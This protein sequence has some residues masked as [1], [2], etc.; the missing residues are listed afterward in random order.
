MPTSLQGIAKKA[1]QEKSYRFRNLFGMLT[2]VYVLSGWPLLN[3]RAATGVDRI[4]ARAYGNRLHDHV[5]SLVERVKTQCYR[6]K[7]VRRHY[8]PK[9]NGALRPL[10]IPATEDKLLQMA[11]A[12]ILDAI[13]EPDFL[14]S[15]YGYRKKIGARDAVRDLTRQLQFGPYNYVVEADIKGFFDHI[16]HERLLEML[17]LRIEDRPFLRLIK[18]WLKAGVLDTDGQ[19]LHPVTGLPQGGIVSPILANIYLHHVLDVWF[20][21]VVQAYCKGQALLCRY[22]DDFVCA[23]Q[24][25]R[26]AE[27]FYGVLGQ[28]L[29]KYGL[30]LSPEKTR[31]LGFSRHPKDAKSRFDFLGFTFLWGKDRKGQDRLQ[32]QTS[33]SRLKKALSNFTAWIKQARNQHV[34]DLIKELNSKLRGYYNY[35]GVRGNFSSL[36][37]FFYHVERLL[38]KWLNRRSQKHSYTWQGFKDLLKQFAIARPRITEP[39]RSRPVTT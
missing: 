1:A 6:A 22:A 21:E 28:R 19:V 2:V 38:Y 30:E 33:R 23:F 3:K 39:A 10:G 18:K 14:S 20:T 7:F 35:Y 13:Y 12:R 4:S 34:P 32:R 25:E 11:V 5:T 9:G 31:L 27:R 15:S 36:D 8:I 16:D 29:E 24:Y 26:D 37:E 17:R